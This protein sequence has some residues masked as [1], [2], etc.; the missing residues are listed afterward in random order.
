MT[1]PMI[2]TVN[3]TPKRRTLD[4]MREMARG[5]ADHTWSQKID[6]KWLAVRWSPDADTYR[7]TIDGKLVSPS[8][9]RALIEAA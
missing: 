3:F 9:A 7:V 5:E 1:H 2:K 8:D 6:G 4:E